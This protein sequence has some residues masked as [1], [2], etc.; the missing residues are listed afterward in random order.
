MK[1]V[2]ITKDSKI[3]RKDNSLILKINNDKFNLPV[4]EIDNIFVFSKIEFNSDF[5]NFLSKNNINIYF[6]NWY[7]GYFGS[8]TSPGP[9]PSGQLVV[10]QVLFYYDKILRLKMAKEILH[11]AFYNMGSILR[12]HKVDANFIKRAISDLKS[13]ASIQEI[14]LLEAN[15]RKKYYAKFNNIL[16][17]KTFVFNLRTRQPPKDPLN[18]MISFGNSL[19]Y[20]TCL[21]EIYKTGLDPKISFLHEPFQRRYSLNLDLSEI[22]KPIIVDKLIFYLINKKIITKKDFRF[23]SDYCLL[24]DSGRKKFLENYDRRLKVTIKHR[25]LKRN[26]SYKY[27]IRLEIYK[28][29]KNILEGEKYKSFKIYW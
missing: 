19:L 28:I 20:N 21:S 17:S 7:G 14:M 26:V 18:A 16:K 6:Y 9:Y 25:K 15:V 8:F 10:K 12:K 11:G 2:Y 27:L 13:K 1:D 24:N 22:F 3:Y 4:E 29:I 23:S 5:L